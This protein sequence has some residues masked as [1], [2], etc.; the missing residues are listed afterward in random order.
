MPTENYSQLSVMEIII[1]IYAAY[2]SSF[3][4]ILNATKI[5]NRSAHEI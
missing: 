1:N 3:I 5:I 4:I 2:S